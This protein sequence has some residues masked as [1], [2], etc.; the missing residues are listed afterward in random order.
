M[1]KVYVMGLCLLVMV[2][3]SCQFSE[4]IYI[5]DDG[6][7][8]ISFSFDGSQLMQMAGDKFAEEGEEA[9]DSTFSFKEIFDEKRDSISK[10]TI[11]EQEKLKSLEDYKMHMVMNP[12]T[13]E[14]K[15]ELFA[16]FKK[17]SEMKDMF[18]AMNNFSNMQGKGSAE[19]NDPN[20][21][22]SSLG[23]G[24]NTKLNYTYSGSTFTR[25]VIVLDKEIQKKLGDSLSEMAAMFGTSTYKLNY[26]FP[27]AVKSVSNEKAMFSADRKTVTL[28]FPFMTYAL[29]PEALNLEIVLED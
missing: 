20:N 24:G 18:K 17:A 14:M 3:T 16:E 21:P 2:F 13:K 4:D 27:R 15:F 12:E 7:G 26:H 25:E 19:V 23:E 11:E 10:L 29:D 6:S 28:E 8:K 9:V 22:F 1:N 5:N